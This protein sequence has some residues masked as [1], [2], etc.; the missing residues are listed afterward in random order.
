M[1]RKYTLGTLPIFW[2]GLYFSL[3]AMAKKLWIKFSIFLVINMVK[4]AGKYFWVLNKPIF[5]VDPKSF[6]PVHNL[7]RTAKYIYAKSHCNTS[8]GLGV[9]GEHLFL[10]NYWEN[11][12]KILLGTLHFFWEGPVSPSPWSFC[13]DQVAGLCLFPWKLLGKRLKNT[14][15]HCAH[16][17]GRPKKF[18]LCLKPSLD[19][20]VHVCKL[21]LQYLKRFRCA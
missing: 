19:Y 14:F 11:G 3:P 16:F 18:Y 1:T 21:S 4:M 12:W 15:G 10:Y 5:W 9:H 8:N 17:L 20:Q 7:P 2:A 13:H 6:K